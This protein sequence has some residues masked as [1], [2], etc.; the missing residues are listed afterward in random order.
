MLKLYN[1]YG[2]IYPPHFKTTAH[3]P[4]ET[5]P[6]PK[7]VILPLQQNAGA[8]PKPV[9]SKGNKVLSGE[10]IARGE[11]AVSVPLHSPVSGEVVSIKP[12]KHPVTG[13]QVES[14]IINSDGFDSP[15]PANKTHHEYFRFSSADLVN[16]IRNAGIVGLGGG[17]FPAHIKAASSAHHSEVIIDTL[18]INAAECEPYLSS[19][20]RLLQEHAKDVVCGAKILMHILDASRTIV[21]IQDNK[22]EAIKK[23]KEI[24]YNEPNIDLAV[25]KTRYPQGSERHLIKTLLNK[26]V[27]S[28]RHPVN[29]GII[30][31]NA[32]TAYA[33]AKAVREGEPLTSRIITVAGSGINNPKNLRVRI[34]AP[35]RDIVE[36]CGGITDGLEQV[37]MGGPMMGIAQSSLDVPVLK[38]TTGIIFLSKK[39]CIKRDYTDC[40]MCGKCSRVCP[41]KL[42]PNMLS[43]NIEKGKLDRA[44]K[45]YPDDCIECGCC[46]Y[47]CPARRP[48]V[49]QIKSAKSVLNA[50]VAGQ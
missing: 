37:I 40:F 23:L 49:M 46:A 9:V 27:P 26:V 16:V 22:P 28:G 36:Y 44:A 38:C 8:T 4:I 14:I 43:T 11:D 33:V 39:D 30:V 7:T 31:N 24:V 10:V 29:I 25:L 42:L 20:D 48:I 15:A 2:G 45:Y 12:S 34:G 41:M 13:E 5:L 3:L 47:I 21:A 6:I 1:F 32:A 17:A 35:L 19:D 50:R 18:I